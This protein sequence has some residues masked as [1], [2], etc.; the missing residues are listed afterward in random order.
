MKCGL[1]ID[2]LDKIF[3]YS[4]SS[5]VINWK[6]LVSEYVYLRKKDPTLKQAIE[7]N[8]LI[9]VKSFLESSLYQAKAYHPRCYLENNNCIYSYRH[10]LAYT[11]CAVAR[12]EMYCLLS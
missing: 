12:V 4:S 3:L 7:N 9:G 11:L 10:S 8:N 5:D 1:P 6:D 2:I